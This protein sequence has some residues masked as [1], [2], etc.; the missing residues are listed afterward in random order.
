MIKEIDLFVLNEACR[1]LAEWTTRDGWPKGF[2]VAV[3]VSGRE[4]SETGFADVDDALGPSD[5]GG[6]MSVGRGVE[7]LRA[8]TPGWGLI[9]QPRGLGEIL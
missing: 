1:Q 5:L 2:T 4:L 8:A 3:N 9:P 6:G 7:R